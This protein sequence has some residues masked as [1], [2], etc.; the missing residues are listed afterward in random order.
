[1]H[2]V[3]FT[4]LQAPAGYSKGQSLISRTEET[5]NEVKFQLGN[6]EGPIGQCTGKEVPFAEL[7]TKHLSGAQNPFDARGC[8]PCACRL[9]QLQMNGTR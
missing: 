1:M 3:E 2:Q 6:C 8:R 5:D 7:R 4:A 9:P